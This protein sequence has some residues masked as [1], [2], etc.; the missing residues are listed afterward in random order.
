M[1]LQHV[2]AAVAKD[3]NIQQVAEDLTAG[4]PARIGTAPSTIP[5]VLAALAQ[6]ARPILVI[7]PSDRA[8]D[9]YAK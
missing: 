3:S 4:V 9:E 5:Y 7:T 8:A 6:S 1:S 2:V